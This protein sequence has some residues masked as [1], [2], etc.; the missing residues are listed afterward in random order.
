MLC[1][2]GPIASASTQRD[3]ESAAKQQKIAFILVHDQSATGVDQA[4]DVIRQTMKQVSKSVLLE[5]DRSAP[6]NAEYVAKLRLAGAPVPLILVAARNGALAGGVPAAQ[7]TPAIL[8][9]MVP[10]PKKAEVLQA[11]Q[12]GKPVFI[13]VSR[14][15]MTSEPKAVAACMSACSKMGDKSALVRIDMADPQEATFLSQLK[16]NS[17][18]TEPVTLVVNAQGQ[19]TGSYA[20]VQDVASLVQAATR[21]AGGCCPSTVQGGSKACA[22]T[23]K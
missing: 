1:T 22:P 7:A 20:Q 9:G 21:V 6:P 18:A 4:R 17:A 3:V 12:S 13:A 10:S 15:G 16:V 2:L 5:L 14:K 8:L 23:K 11:L 19:V